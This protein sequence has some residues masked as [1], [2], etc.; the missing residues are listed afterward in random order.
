MRRKLS[1]AIRFPALA[2]R[3]GCHRS[4]CYDVSTKRRRLRLVSEFC[5][6]ALFSS[7][8]LCFTAQGSLLAVYVGTA[9]SY[10]S[11]RPSPCYIHLVFHQQPKWKSCRQR[12][13]PSPT[14][15]PQGYPPRPPKPQPEDAGGG[16]DSLP[17]GRRDLSRDQST[18]RQPTLDREEAGRKAEVATERAPHGA[19]K[20][21][22]RARRSSILSTAPCWRRNCGSRLSGMRARRHMCHAHTAPFLVS[23]GLVHFL[24]SNP[25]TP[26]V[27]PHCRY[28]SSSIRCRSGVVLRRCGVEVDTASS[29]RARHTYVLCCRKKTCQIRRALLFFLLAPFSCFFF[30]QWCSC[31]GRCRGRSPHGSEQQESGRGPWK[32]RLRGR[33]R[34]VE[35][36]QDARRQG[37]RRNKGMPRS[38]VGFRRPGVKNS[39]LRGQRKLRYSFCPCERRDGGGF[40]SCCVLRL[41]FGA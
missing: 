26:S 23:G 24:V 22:A 6:I 3:V 41:A 1:R 20:G 39:I 38:A 35:R 40:S 34:L 29:P 27:R 18:V 33:A 15:R 11:N 21:T 36:R 17:A 7:R 2:V 12:N 14:A 25:S 32:A 37:R 4:A 30:S 10:N 5:D 8:Y 31:R 16:R 19:C 9:I 28:R 13:A